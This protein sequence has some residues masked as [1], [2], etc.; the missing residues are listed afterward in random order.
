[1]GCSTIGGSFTHYTIKL[2]PQIK[3]LRR[4]FL[5]NADWIYI[6]SLE[7]EYQLSHLMS[8]TA[9]KQLF[10]SVPQYPCE[11]TAGGNGTHLKGFGEDRAW[12]NISSC[13]NHRL[14]T[15]T[16]PLPYTEMLR[17]HTG[18]GARGG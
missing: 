9:N 5:K 6:D 18:T 13:D 8:V 3:S 12:K 1:M 16:N 15:H 11:Y 17:T 10:L 14:P 2:T 4:F 7:F